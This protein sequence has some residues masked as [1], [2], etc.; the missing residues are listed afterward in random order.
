M[1][2]STRKY[3]KIRL[4]GS[5]KRRQFKRYFIRGKNKWNKIK[6]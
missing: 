6:K 4:E 3:I 2:R 5:K 1:K